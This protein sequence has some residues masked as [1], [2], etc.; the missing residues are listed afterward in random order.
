MSR[1]KLVRLLGH[2]F[3]VED[4]DTSRQD[5]AQRLGQWLNAFDAVRLDGALHVIRK[6]APQPPQTPQAATVA[7]LDEALRSVRVA[8]LALSPAF[9]VDEAA[10]GFDS[11]RQRYLDCQRQMELKIA[12]LR[13]QVRQV[14]A[15]SSTRLKQLAALD[16]VLEHVL[17]GSARRLMA[18]VPTLLERRFEHL[19][20]TQQAHTFGQE[21]QAV[22][23]A[24][25]DM[26][27]QPVM[28]LLEALHKHENRRMNR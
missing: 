28:G 6:F 20:S 13:A 7:M 8:L 14:L 24:E 25:I 16:A 10:K 12:P 11:C 9:P 18:T 4:S 26:R 23:Q 5:F 17:E 21:F 27:L 19:C 15:Q 3:P 2:W 22:L 1:P